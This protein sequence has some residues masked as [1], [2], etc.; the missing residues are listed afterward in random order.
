MAPITILSIFS[1]IL[2]IIIMKVAGDAFDRK[3]EVERVN[4]DTDAAVQNCHRLRRVFF[5]WVFVGLI[6]FLAG[7]YGVLLAVYPAPII[8]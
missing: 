8:S 2:G 5:L 1:I 7:I 3:L 4:P 6:P